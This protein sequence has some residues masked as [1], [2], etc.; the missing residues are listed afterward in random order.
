[1]SVPVLSTTSVVAR[2]SASSAS[3]FRTSTPAVAPRPTPTMTDIGVAR[4]SA[5]GQAMISTDTAADE[6]VGEAGLGADERPGHERERRHGD[7]RRHEPGGDAVG[8]PLDGRAAALRLAHERD[9]AREQRLATDALGTHHE[10]AGPVER[11]PGDGALPG[12]SRRASARR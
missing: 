8:Q 4:P 3:A 1:M 2:A 12:P 10:A 5:H 7:H 9:D 11:G 6:R